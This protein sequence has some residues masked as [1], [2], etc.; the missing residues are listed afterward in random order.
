M[1]GVRAGVPAPTEID[2]IDPHYVRVSPV[3]DL[4]V[5]PLPNGNI[6]ITLLK[7]QPDVDGELVAMV[8]H[9]VEWKLEALMKARDKVAAGM[10]PGNVVHMTPVNSLAS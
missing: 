10:D 8:M 1:A 6:L 3:D 4:M 7:L 9:R 2:V 5:V